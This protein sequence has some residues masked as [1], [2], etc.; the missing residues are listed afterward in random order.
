MIVVMPGKSEEGMIGSSVLKRFSPKHSLQRQDHL[1]DLI[2]KTTKVPLSF[3][4]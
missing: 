4:E 3:Y 1:T 2:I